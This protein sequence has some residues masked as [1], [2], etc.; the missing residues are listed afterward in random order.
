MSNWQVDIRVS[1]SSSVDGGARMDLEL[2]SD[3][4][5]RDEVRQEFV[6]PALRALVEQN[7]P[8]TVIDLGAKTGYAPAA[9]LNPHAPGLEPPAFIAV[10]Q[11]I[12]AVEYMRQHRLGPE[13]VEIVHASAGEW[14]HRLGF[15][16]PR[17]RRLHILSYT[18]LE[19][20]DAEL[21][22]IFAAVTG[23]DTLIVFLPDVAKDAEAAGRL[24]QFLAGGSVSLEKGDKFTGR[25]YPFVAR[26]PEC[27]LE[28]AR[29][30]GLELRRTSTYRTVD[31]HTHFAYEL[32]AMS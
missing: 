12:V 7:R 18:A 4:C 29:D 32:R 11:D 28:W 15:E 2:W 5:D 27:W 23:D 20:E 19:L 21:R 26:R 25:P 9:L 6:L 3:C 13:G 8:A 14:Q 16:P 31:G 30:A 1:P 17:G 10:D 24:T 22:A